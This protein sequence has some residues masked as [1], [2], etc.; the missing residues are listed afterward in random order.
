MVGFYA[1]TVIFIDTVTAPCSADDMFLKIYSFQKGHPNQKG[2][3]PDTLDT[4]PPGSAPGVDGRT[5]SRHRCRGR[6]IIRTSHAAL[7]HLHRRE[8]ARRRCWLVRSAVVAVDWIAV[9]WVTRSGALTANSID[10]DKRS[11]SGNDDDQYTLRRRRRET[12]SNRYPTH[13]LA[14]WRQR[15]R[16]FQAVLHQLGLS[17]IG[18]RFDEPLVTTTWC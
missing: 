10:D 9:V 18:C 17:V 2:G 3:C 14:A 16:D 6:Y 13:S 5:D 12:N 8:H 11:T 7:Q 15:R 4:L 1:F